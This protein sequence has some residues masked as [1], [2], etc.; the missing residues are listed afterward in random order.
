MTL[1]L[2][3]IAAWGSQRFS[4]LVA[5]LPL[6]IPLEGESSEIAEQRIAEFQETVNNI[7]MDLFVEFFVIA[8]VVTVVAIVP[9][10]LMA[11]SRARSHEAEESAGID[12]GS[13]RSPA[14]GDPVTDT[15]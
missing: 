5:G 8:A 15:D 2:A 7:G 14:S 10:L 1:G 9:A 6:P 12:E 4:I 3:A 13:E 11:W